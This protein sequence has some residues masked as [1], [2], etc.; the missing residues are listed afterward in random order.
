MQNRLLAGK[1]AIVT[2]AGSPIGMGRAMT[3]GLVRAGAR[4]AMLDVN[5][6]WLGPTADEVRAVGGDDSV[7]ALVA[8]VSDPDSAEE[9]VRKTIAALGG[10]HV[11]VNNA[12]V[13]HDVRDR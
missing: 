1:I 6:D 5:E 12:G 7:L 9:A 10:L 11:L 3:L 8:D 2:G 4:V 13:I